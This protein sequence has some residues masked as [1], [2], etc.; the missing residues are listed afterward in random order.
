MKEKS[1]I[2]STL[3]SYL[4]ELKRDI[5]K[6]EWQF[7]LIEKFHMKENTDNSQVK[8]K[9]NFFPDKDNNSELNTFF[10]NLWNISLK[11]KTT[12]NNLSSNKDKP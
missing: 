12:Y 1:K 10:K 3:E 2:L 11:E 9:S 8:N 5:K 7:R 6:F 4:G